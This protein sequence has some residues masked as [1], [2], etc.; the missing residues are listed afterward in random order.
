MT[1]KALLFDLDGLLVDSEPLSRR[2]WSEVI[3]Q[4]GYTLS[5][6]VF[7]QMIGR[8]E[9][10]VR[11]LFERVFGPDFP[12]EQ[13]TRL[14]QVHFME[15][16]RREGV[17]PKPGARDLLAEVTRRGLAKAVASS[18]SRAMA[19]AKL[20]S[21]GLH[22]F[23]EVV[24]TG[25]D[26]PRAKPAPDLF[27]EASRRLSLPPAACVVLEDSSVG[28]QAA[29]AAGMRCI[30]I[31]DVQPV[32]AEIARLATWQLHSLAEVPALLDHL[33]VNG[34]DPAQAGSA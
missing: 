10:E 9:S 5:E 32:P 4:L 26:V 23:F 14:R 11:T 28:V 33:R 12:F 19:E 8:S 16:L 27:L 6:D 15:A 31:P 30:L 29:H 24:V 34:H 1:V 2:S 21:A 17:P 3:A 7:L 20:R 13:A 18:T 22:E 25:E